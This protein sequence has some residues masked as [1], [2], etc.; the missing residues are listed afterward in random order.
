MIGEVALVFDEVERR[1]RRQRHEPHHTL[2]YPP[3]D[4]L[5]GGR[6]FHAVSLYFVIVWTQDKGSMSQPEPFSLSSSVFVKSATG[7][8]WEAKLPTNTVLSAVA[9]SSLMGVP[10][11]VPAPS[12]ISAPRPI[13]SS[14]QMI[15]PKTK[16]TMCPNDH[17]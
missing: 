3:T 11:F 6:Y 16:H 14:A 10:F 13:K 1:R 9:G 7:G 17:P 5:N 15:I 2:A 8:F 4:R 12:Y